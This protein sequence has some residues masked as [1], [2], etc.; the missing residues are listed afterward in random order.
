MT[1]GMAASPRL[2][3]ALGAA[4]AGVFCIDLPVL[5]GA[6]VEHILRHA[7][8][9]RRTGSVTLF[10]ADGW[11]AGVATVPLTRG[12]ESAARDLYR[13]ILQASR[14]VHLARIWNYVPAINA[15]SV[16]D[17]VENYRL[18]CRG[19]SEAFEQQHGAGYKSFLPSASAVGTAAD[20]LTVVFAASQ[21]TPRH[22]ENPMQMPA[23]EYPVDYGPS[24]PS[25]ARA[26]LVPG[27]DRDTVFISGTA[28]IRGHVAIAPGRTFDQLDCTLENLRGISGACGLGPALAADRKCARYFKVYL[29]HAADQPAVAATL[30]KQLLLPDDTVSYLHSDICRAELNVEIE[31]TLWPPAAG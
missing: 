11:L 22:V 7:R 12:L 21:A 14:D 6:P 1:G 2:R 17:G 10:E 23:Y 26:T 5:A 9:S 13:D 16:P 27:R 25:F 15:I 19:R 24:A 29:R 3:V 28:A 18:F 4:D 8:L 20:T 30:Q 31:A